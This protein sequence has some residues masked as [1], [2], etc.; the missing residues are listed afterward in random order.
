MTQYIESVQNSR[1]KEWAKL[2]QKKYREAKQQFLVEGWHLV[3]EAVKADIVETIISLEPYNSSYDNVL[4]SEAVLAKLA[5]TKS[6]QPVMAVC[7]I[8][9]PML[10]SEAKRV[11]VLDG[12]QDPGNVGTL[13]RSAAAFGVDAILVTDDAVDCFNEKVVRASQGAIFHLPVMTLAA[14][15]IAALIDERQLPLLLTMM[16]GKDVGSWEA[17][18]AWALVLGNEGQG[19]RDFWQGLPHEAL[20]I[21]MHAVTESLNVAVAGSIMLWQLTRGI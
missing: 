17:G 21:K 10:A 1:V 16:D 9:R 12:L 3:E 19:I 15:E 18:A 14:S 8:A 11:V 4:V 6:P 20:T 7:R 5:V 2:Q 13:I